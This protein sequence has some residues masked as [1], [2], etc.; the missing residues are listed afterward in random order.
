MI[1]YVG[2]TRTEG[3]GD[4]AVIL[5]PL[6]GIFDHQLN[7]GAGRQPFKHAGK[8]TNR[9]LFAA[10]GRVFVLSGF[11][12]IQPGLNIT[13]GQGDAGRAAVDGCA[14]RWPVAFTP[15]G[16]AEQVA[17]GVETHIIIPMLGAT[18]RRNCGKNEEFSCGISSALAADVKQGMF[19][20]TSGC[21]QW[22][23][24][25]NADP[26]NLNRLRPAEGRSGIAPP[27]L[28]P[29]QMEWTMKTP[30]LAAGF[31]CMANLAFAETPVLN[32]LTYD[33]FVSEWGPGPAI[34]KAFEA[35]CAC[36]LTFTG[37]GDG[38]A[39]LAR[40]QLEG[41]ASEADVVVGIDTSLTAQAAATGLFAPHGIA[42]ETN[43]PVA[44][45]DPNFLPYD[46]GWFAFV[47]DNTKLTTVP[48][49]FEELAA[50][51][52]KI[53]IQDPRSSTPGLGLLLWVK[54][55]YGDKSGS[56]WEAL[57]RQHRDRDPRLV[58]SVRAFSGRRG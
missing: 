5:G 7:G 27:I 17:E 26:S 2:M 6:V 28:R 52:L 12:R 18:H 29:S 33:S 23:R 54:A 3:L 13:L 31:L 48:R 53:V 39:L 20:P 19:S 9:I 1:G 38:A 8:D 43:L 21:L 10:L 14:D 16:N 4:I 34:E 11:A 55:A 47:Y 15:C 24:C 22:L 44:F 35:E 32:V 50:S 51:D 58:R 57:A 42:A 41:A 49:S 37:A 30:I 36:D 25:R 56:I 45:S 40:V 46:W